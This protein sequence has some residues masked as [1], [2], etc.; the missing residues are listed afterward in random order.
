MLSY[1]RRVA[2][3]FFRRA[4]TLNQAPLNRVSLGVLLVIDGVILFNVFMGLQDISRWPLSPPEA[5]PCYGPWQTYQQDIGPN[6][7]MTFLEASYNQWPPVPVPLTEEGT[8]QNGI[9]PR[10][11]ISTGDR[12]R[13]VEAG[14]LGQVS[15]LCLTYGE[16]EQAFWQGEG[17]DLLAQRAQ[18]LAERHDLELANQRIRAEY[19][20]T[21]LESIAGQA[22]DASITTTPAAEARATL[23]RNG[24]A[25]ARLDQ[26]IA[27]LE[28]QILATPEGEAL[29]NY[30]ND[31]GAFTTLQRSQQKAQFWHAT[32]QVFLQGLFLLP[33]LVVTGAVHR[34]SESRGYDLLAL[35]SWHLLVIFSIPLLIK[36]L[37]LLQVGV[38]LN[39]MVAIAANLF[40]GLLFMVSYLYIL[41]VPI[42]G[43]G[44]IK[45]CQ[46][47]VFNPKVQ[48]ANRVQKSRCIRCARK[49]QSD[50]SYC[51]HC[52]Y[53]QHQECSHCHQPTYVHLP[54]CRHCGQPQTPQQPGGVGV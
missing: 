47:L 15:P 25:I 52:G 42:L 40:G 16:Y 30:L 43:F 5:Y 12:Y 6:R 7:E 35:L 14:R 22:P 27:T 45:V 51:P 31:D 1:L 21:L 3:R 19:D 44:I 10:P 9:P 2:R 28:S 23:D 17:Y 50:D 53:H 11:E 39:A 36:V 48:A 32:Q 29:F 33:L 8:D 41:I 54:Y 18:K 46:G 37:E 20:S 34:H 49:I 26:D 4:H 24:A 38:I 13:Q